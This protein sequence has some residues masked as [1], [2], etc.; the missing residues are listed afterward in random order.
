MSTFDLV[1]KFFALCITIVFLYIVVSFKL[2]S[3]MSLNLPK[4]LQISNLINSL[5]LNSENRLK[6]E[7]DAT[8]LKCDII[9]K[10]YQQYYHDFD[11][12][13]YPQY[14]YLSQNYSINFECLNKSSPMKTI[15]AWNKFYGNLKNCFYTFNENLKNL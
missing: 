4:N 7:L 3:F 2:V 14:L 9:H 1:K 12:V 13:K 8:K 6:H 10:D 11:G 15:L 5:D